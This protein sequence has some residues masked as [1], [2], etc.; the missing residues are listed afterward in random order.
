MTEANCSFFNGPNGS[1]IISSQE[2]ADAV[3]SCSNITADITIQNY[4]TSQLILD[5]IKRIEGNLD[6]SSSDA[7]E[8]LS[9]PALRT[10]TEN[11]TVSG[12][13]NLQT[14]DLVLLDNVNGGIYLDT[15]PALTEV[16]F[17][18]LRSTPS[19]LPGANVDGNIL[20]S[21]TGLTNLTFLNFTHY[22]EPSFIRISGNLQLDSINLTG[23]SWGSNSL[24]ILDNGPSAQIFLPDLQSVGALTISSAG[25]ADL[26][27]LSTVNTDMVLSDNSFEV[28]RSPILASIGGTFLVSNNSKLTDLDL[29][30]LTTIG[31]GTGK[32]NF[33]VTNNTALQFITNLDQFVQA[34]GN[35]TLSGNFSKYDLHSN[36]ERVFCV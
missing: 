19:G 21:N 33:T 10:I 9:L 14:L 27:S 25:D 13:P 2:A 22:S 20:V 24:E 31:D 36:L 4:A 8:Q 12:L 16:S 18:S 6:I 30:E 28:F 29:P 32:G 5:G 35:I 15:L 7:L 34:Q 11:F 3:S 17:G 1:L 26:S 23:L